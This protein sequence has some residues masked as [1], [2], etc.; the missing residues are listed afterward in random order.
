[1]T[2][3]QCPRCGSTDVKGAETTYLNWK[4][5]RTETMPAYKCGRCEWEGP[6]EMLQKQK[7]TKFTRHDMKKKSVSNKKDEEN[8]Y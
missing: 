3:R 4:T 5:H 6:W 1:M 2:S 7:S 8:D